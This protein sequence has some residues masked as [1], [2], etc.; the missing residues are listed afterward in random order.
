M[1]YSVTHRAKFTRHVKESK[2]AAQEVKPAH[3]VWLTAKESNSAFRDGVAIVQERDRTERGGKG[4]FRRAPPSFHCHKTKRSTDR[5]PTE[6]L[7]AC[8][9]T[10]KIKLLP[11]GYIS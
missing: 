8:A 2:E 9:E 6:G 7:L 10:L 4:V 11:F 5:L 1:Y 3:Q